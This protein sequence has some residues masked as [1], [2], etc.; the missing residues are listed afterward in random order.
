MP[1][2][3]VWNSGG[4]PRMSWLAMVGP[5]AALLGAG[6]ADD[7]AEDAAG[8]DAAAD[9]GADADDAAAVVTGGTLLAVLDVDLLEAQ[10]ASPRERVMPVTPMSRSLRFMRN[11]LVGLSS[12]STLRSLPAR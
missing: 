2:T 4:A 1:S 7:A 10:P 3:R 9:D 8:T 12:L 11:L 5:L 6:A